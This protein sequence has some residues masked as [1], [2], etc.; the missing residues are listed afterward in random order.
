MYIEIENSQ[1]NSR[2]TLISSK[3]YYVNILHKS[4]KEQ[5]EYNIYF[6]LSNIYAY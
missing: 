6:L 4:N 1:I 5:Q 3:L 2:N